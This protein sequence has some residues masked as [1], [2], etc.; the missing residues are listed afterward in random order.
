MVFLLSLALVDRINI[1]KKEKDELV[2]KQTENLEREVEIRT[3][4][5]KESEEKYRGFFKTSTDCVYIVTKEGEWIDMSDGAPGF[6][7]YE[8]KE[9]LQKIN[10]RELYVNKSDRE[11]DVLEIEKK[12]TVKDSL[13]N[14]RRKDGSIINVL[15]SSVAIKDEDGNVVVFQGSIR[16]ITAQKEA[17]ITLKKNQ[18]YLQE[19]NASKDKFFSIISHDLRSPFNSILGFS[20]LLWTNSGDF[21]KAEIE[22]IAY[23]IYKTGNET[24]DLLNNLLEWSSSQTGKLKIIPENFF[25]KSIVDETIDLLNEFATKKNITVLN[26]VTGQIKVFADKNMI[27]SVIRNL[28]SNAIKFTQNGNVR[29]TAKDVNSFVEF[30]ITDTGVGIKPEDIN[31]LFR[32]DTE[33]STLGTAN[34]KGSGLGLILCKEFIEKNHGEINVKS[35]EGKGTGFMLKLPNT[36]NYYSD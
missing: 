1:L 3:I 5:L 21:S 11:K 22:K 9:E 8:S 29:I 16:D 33:F 10:I 14:L 31:K 24:I 34:E 12:G 25:L 20:E 18:E 15:I 7:G 35:E 26:E 28:L 2:L 36:K 6:F 19:L 23:N 4:A 32:L 17:E 27:S 13:F 30:L